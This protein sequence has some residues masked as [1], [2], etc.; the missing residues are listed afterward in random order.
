MIGGSRLRSI[1]SQ[2]AGDF[3]F[4]WRIVTGIRL[5]NALSSSANGTRRSDPGEDWRHVPGDR[6]LASDE[7]NQHCTSAAPAA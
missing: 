1:E 7:E 2:C 5:P 3:E 6:P 4:E